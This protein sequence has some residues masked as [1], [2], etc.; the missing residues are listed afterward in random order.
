M[1]DINQVLLCGNLGEDPALLK[2]S[3]SGNFVRLSVAT[4]KKYTNAKGEVIQ[5]TQWHTV[6]LSNGLGKYAMSTFK[7]GMQ[8]FILGE[9]RKRE[10]QDKN[11]KAQYTTAVYAKVCRLFAP[12]ADESPEGQ[13][14]NEDDFVREYENAKEA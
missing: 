10:W 8:V 3:K 13:V 7:K 11:G 6:Y 9:L 4:N 1:F 14:A 5:D 2:E 12:K